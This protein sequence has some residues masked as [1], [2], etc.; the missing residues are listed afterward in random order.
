MDIERLNITILLVDDDELVT[1]V[2]SEM[3]AYLGY[4]VLT[5]SSGKEAVDT[6]A[7]K[8]DAVDLIILDMIMNGM[9]GEEAFEAIRAINNDVPVLLCSG[10]RMDRQASQILERGFDGY[11]QK[12]FELN[13]L[14]RSIREIL[15][16]R[17]PAL[18]IKT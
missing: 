15:K 5:A 16:K 2:G 3:L 1:E 7:G 17:K 14:S 10:S 13:V 12:P 11:I 9:S 18:D 8:G 6:M 4:Q